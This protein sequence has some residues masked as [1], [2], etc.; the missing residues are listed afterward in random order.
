LTDSKTWCK[1]SERREVVAMTKEEFKERVFRWARKMG[2]FPKEVQIRKMRRN[3]WGSCSSTGRICFN[4]ELL[5]KDKK[6]ID[7]V[8]V[9]EL[10]HLKYKNHGKIFKLMWEI[11]LKEGLE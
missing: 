1:I 9:H 2:V 11:Y 10:L 5:E 6:F 8:I 3:R 4:E 7:H